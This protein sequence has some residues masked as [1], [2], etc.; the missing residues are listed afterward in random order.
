MTAP[1]TWILAAIAALSSIKAARAIRAN[2]QARSQDAILQEYKDLFALPEDQLQAIR[3]EVRRQ[4]ELGL[5]GQKEGL[6]MLPSYVDVLPSG[7]E[8]GEF[9]AVDLGGTNLRVMWVRLSEQPGVV[10]EEDIQEWKIPEECYDTDNGK[11]FPWVVDCALRVMSLHTSSKIPI[12]GFC[13][14]FACRQTALDRGTLLLWTKNFRGRGLLGQDIVKSLVACFEARGVPV[15]VP[16]LANDTV[17]TLV[18]LCYSKPDTKAGVILGTGTNCAYLESCNCIA[19]LPTDYCPGGDVM[20]INTEWGDLQGALL[21]RCD[22]D[23]WLD[24]AS[25]NPGHG[26][27]EKMISGLYMGDLARRI[28]LRLAEHGGLFTGRAMITPGK[29]LASEGAFG[30]SSLSAV[31]QDDSPGLIVTAEILR[32]DLGLQKVPLR[33]L[34]IVQEVCRLVARRSARLCAAAMAAVLDRACPKSL[35]NS[36]PENSTITVAVDGSVFAKYVAFRSALRDALGELIGENAA[37][38]VQLQLV[39]D[40]SVAGAAFLAAAVSRIEAEDASAL[41]LA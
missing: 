34:R 18:A 36:T 27:F 1:K 23:E 19:A 9:F 17:A 10:D 3:A 33:D 7:M 25:A 38:S 20:V 14:S 5:Q 41:G 24:C 12:V 30:S 26:L 32:K 15:R 11:L 35:A 13:F 37:R 2:K 8:Q 40:G 31:D 4:M 39:R 16:A 22:E 21:P 6:M 28:M 29:G